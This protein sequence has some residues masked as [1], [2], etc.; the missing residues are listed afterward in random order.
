[1]V[2]KN[3]L[4]RKN[5]T[6]RLESLEGR[7]MMAGGSIGQIINL[8]LTTV[9]V[10]TE[11]FQPVDIHQGD[12][13]VCLAKWD[14]QA[15]GARGFAQFR[16]ALLLPAVGS[17]S[18]SNNFSNLRLLAN[19]NGVNNDG[20][21]GDG[22]EAEIGWVM[23]NWET[24]VM[25]AQIGYPPVWAR[26]SQDLEIELVGNANSWLSGENAGVEFAWGS[27]SDLRGNYISDG[28]IVYD[29][30]N[31]VLTPIN[32][33]Y[34][35]VSQMQVDKF[36][37][38]LVGQQDVIL[39]E[40]YAYGHEANLTQVSFTTTGSTEN[41]ENVTL[42]VDTNW[43]NNP[44]QTFTGS[45][46]NGIMSFNLGADGLQ[47][48][49][50]LLTVVADVVD[51]LVGDPNFQASLPYDSVGVSAVDINTGEPLDQGQIHVYAGTGGT[52]FN[53]V[54]DTQVVIKELQS[55]N[56]EDLVPGT[57]VVVEN[58]TVYA[59]QAGDTLNRVVITT[60]I[61]DVSLLKSY[62][63]LVDTNGDLT[64]ETTIAFGVA[65]P[66]NCVVFENFSQPIATGLDSTVFAVQANVPS[67]LFGYQIF[68]GQL[69]GA[70]G[71]VVKKKDGSVLPRDQIF[72]GYSDQ[73][74]FYSEYPL[75]MG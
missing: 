75:G 35:Q 14:I 41:F 64:P 13:N 33:T 9:R 27:F 62:A 66:N 3:T 69:Y 34:V 59:E 58:F 57:T 10:T 74:L 1:M 16:E 54:S 46:S 72:M 53:L 8:P 70:G 12:Q 28:N 18:I 68:R 51:Q 37:S 63:L 24:G 15:E 2:R 67:D 47:S 55:T 26:A 56:Q 21:R 43:D 22:Y 36:G 4:N 60:E 31:P 61:G 20:V 32:D 11:E 48:S 50:A 45:T 30:V 23:T 6:L 39:E 17:D 5:R 7:H 38:L 73:T 52:A 25:D 40:V 29:G 71:M 65:Q 19:L 42:Q 44:D 49:G